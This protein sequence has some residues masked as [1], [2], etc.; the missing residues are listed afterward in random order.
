VFRCLGDVCKISY[1]QMQRKKPSALKIYHSNFPQ[2][3]RNKI[4]T[5]MKVEFYMDGGMT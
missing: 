3:Y 2:F 5:I 4:Q 1:L